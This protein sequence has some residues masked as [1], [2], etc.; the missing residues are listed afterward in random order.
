M[1]RS[2]RW[3]P[4]VLGQDGDPTVA[5]TYHGDVGGAT[6]LHS[7]LNSEVPNSLMNRLGEGRGSHTFSIFNLLT[8]VGLN[9]SLALSWSWKKK[10][11]WLA[12]SPQG[13][14]L[15]AI[16]FHTELPQSKMSLLFNID[17]IK[18]RVWFYIRALISTGVRSIW[19]TFMDCLCDILER[20]SEAE[21]LTS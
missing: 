18:R 15:T 2:L 3:Y 12:F 1:N 19:H 8:T 4:A 7:K 13:G 5:L 20:F 6:L 14:I 10:K 9:W 16:W 11:I 17:D 21:Y